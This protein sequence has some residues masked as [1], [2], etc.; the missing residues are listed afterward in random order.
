MRLTKCVWEN[1]NYG[2][3]HSIEV[4]EP[5]EPRTPTF[6]NP[7]TLVVIPVTLQLNS[8][9]KSLLGSSDMT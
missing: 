8:S 6:S 9:L 2:Y 4:K 1:T 7:G 3:I 5:L